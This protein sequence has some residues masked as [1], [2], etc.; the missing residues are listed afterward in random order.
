M[1]EFKL[2][3]HR[4]MHF[5]KNEENTLFSFFNAI[6]NNYEGFECDVRQTKDEKLI[7][8]HDILYKGKML[9]NILYKNI[10]NA[11]LL[12]NVLKIKTDK[13][14]L[15]EIKDPFTNIEKLKDLLFKYKNKNIY[16][17][18]FHD[19]IIDKLNVTGKTYKVG[20]LNYVL[21]TNKSHFKYDFICILNTL[22]NQKT[23]DYIFSNKQ[24]LFIYGIKEN[25]FTYK[26]P[27]YIVN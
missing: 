13:I 15:L 26:W 23:I 27:Y 2:I 16:V 5:N 7:I 6:N 11:L 10:D 17:M 18:S 12:E 14:I 24:E 3:A 19:S 4:G 21:N 8:Y 1:N 9:R 22:L 20:V 25:K